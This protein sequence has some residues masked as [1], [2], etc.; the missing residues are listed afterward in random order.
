MVKFLETYNLPKLNP[1]ETESLNWPITNKETESVIK[2]LPKKKS[3]GPDGFTG[4][5]HQTVKEKINTILF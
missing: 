1:K 3:P 4:K 5:F 2:T